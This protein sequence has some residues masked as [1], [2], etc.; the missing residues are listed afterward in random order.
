MA[1]KKS[2]PTINWK[3]AMGRAEERIEAVCKELEAAR[4]DRELDEEFLAKQ[5]TLLIELT[6]IK[7]LAHH[8]SL[9]IQTEVPGNPCTFE[10]T[11]RAWIPYDRWKD[12]VSLADTVL[13]SCSAYEINRALVRR[14]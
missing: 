4:K 7:N 13:K 3:A 1:K 9:L 6:N 10:L 11:G 5:L 2:K 14:R 12:I 8:L